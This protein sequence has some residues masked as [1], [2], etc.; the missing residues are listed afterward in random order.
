MQNADGVFS[1]IHYNFNVEFTQAAIATGTH[2][3]DLGGNSSI[4][5]QQ[6]ESSAAARNAGVTIVPDCGLAPGMASVLVAGGLRRFA[7]ADT[8]K[9]RVGGLPAEPRDPFRFERLFSV[10]GLINE[11]VESPIMLRD[12]QIVTGEPLGDI[13]EVVFDEPIG[14]LEA[15]NTAGGVSTLPQTYRNRLRNLDY[16]TLRYPGHWA[17]MQWLFHLGL[18]SSDPV[19]V[20]GNTV[21]PRRLIGDRIESS[22]PLCRRDRTVVRIEFSGYDGGQKRTRRLDIV[23]EYDDENGLTSMMRMTAFPASIILQMICDGRI[24]ARGVLPQEVA[25]NPEEFA[26]ELDRRVICV[27]ES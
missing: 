8:V 17:A 24:T 2:M 16:K 3:I 23:D 21:V 5:A 25:V 19:I 22:I 18:M 27:T 20:D 1:A 9:I 12:G 26:R 13:E 15:F 10:E 7:W 4:V 14:T 11:Y 6:L